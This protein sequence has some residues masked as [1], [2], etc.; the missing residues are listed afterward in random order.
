MSEYLT[1]G[2][3]VDVY[4]E[5]QTAISDITDNNLFDINEKI[6]ETRIKIEVELNKQNME[7][8]KDK[9]K[10]LGLSGFSK[11]KPELVQSLLHEFTKLV[12]QL[13]DKKANELKTTCKLHNI[14]CT[15]V[16]KD[17]LLYYLL[18][19]LLNSLNFKLDETDVSIAKSKEPKEKRRHQRKKNLACLNTNYPL[20]N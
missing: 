8:L 18:D 20:Q 19:Y 12:E 9:C 5:T 4:N 11:Q 7:G 10:E 15:T 16:K 13:K 6:H 14:K 17:N 3:C 1:K 2:S